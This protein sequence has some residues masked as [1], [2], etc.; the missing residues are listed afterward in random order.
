MQ[1]ELTY[2][3]AEEA[4]K[5]YVLAR[6]AGGAA[7]EANSERVPVNLSLVVD[8]TTFPQS[9]VQFLVRTDFQ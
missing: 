1:I 2:L 4:S 5:V 6:V 8:Q 9:L 3:V 7:P